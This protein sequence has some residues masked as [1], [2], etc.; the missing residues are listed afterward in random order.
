MSNLLNE[1]MD[2]EIYKGLVESMTESERT[3]VEEMVRDFVFPLE[4]SL[5]VF[6]ECLKD[7]EA[8]REL[9]KYGA[10]QRKD[11]T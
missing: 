3:A 5:K 7:P 1:V 11:S 6:E 10:T 4:E 2:N 8:V 9:Q